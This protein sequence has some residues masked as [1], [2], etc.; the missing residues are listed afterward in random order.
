MAKTAKKEQAP[1]AN[2]ATNILRTSFHGIMSANDAP[3]DLTITRIIIMMHMHVVKVEMNAMPVSD[4]KYL[5]H[6][7]SSDTNAT[8]VKRCAL[9]NSRPFP[10]ASIIAEPGTIRTRLTSVTI[11][12]RFA[13]AA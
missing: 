7:A 10:K 11:R 5:T 8:A 13:D 4:G 3:S 6:R 2:A 9:E 12:N 1:A